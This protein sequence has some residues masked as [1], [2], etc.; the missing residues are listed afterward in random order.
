MDDD[1]FNPDATEFKDF[2][3][4]TRLDREDSKW[5]R[6][7]WRASISASALLTAEEVAEALPGR[8]QINRRWLDVVPRVR[9]PNGQEVF[10]WAEVL[11]HLDRVA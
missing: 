6:R 10:Q 8:A 5:R 4:Y 9:L 2:K 1:D 3:L 11:R 7:M